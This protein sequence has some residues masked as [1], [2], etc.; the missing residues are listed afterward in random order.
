MVV[1]PPMVRFSSSPVEFAPSPGVQESPPRVDG[2]AGW[3]PSTLRE[4]MWNGPGSWSGNV[5]TSPSPSSSVFWPGRDSFSL[6]V[7]HEVAPVEPM[8]TTMQGAWSQPSASQ[9]MM[10]QRGFEPAADVLL[11]F[12]QS[13]SPMDKSSSSFT[14]G[15]APNSPFMNS[16]SM[17]NSIEGMLS[18]R[19]TDP[20]SMEP[21]GNPFGSPGSPLISQALRAAFNEPAP[22]PSSSIDTSMVGP[23]MA[24]LLNN[25]NLQALPA[26]IGNQTTVAAGKVQDGPIFPVASNAPSQVASLIEPDV[27]NADHLTSATGYQERIAIRAGDPGRASRLSGASSNA[28]GYYHSCQPAANFS[29]SEMHEEPAV[30]V[31][32]PRAQDLIAEA[33]PVRPGIDRTCSRAVR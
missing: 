6:M 8:N 15:S 4:D 18:N 24:G 29:D 22:S 13:P 9:G 17:S 32:E 12:M 33:R 14:S 1:P 11:I 28:M 5:S 27:I 26:A 2:Q 21:P 31:A 25:L 3:G 23:F 16:G 10:P 20:P 19:G 7:S 30:Q